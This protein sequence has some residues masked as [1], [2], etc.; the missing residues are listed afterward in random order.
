[1]IYSFLQNGDSA[2]TI[3]F[4]NKISEDVNRRVTT[5]CNTIEAKSINGVIELVPTFASLTVFYDCTIISSKRLK[6]KIKALINDGERS[7][8]TKAI[9]WNIPVC[10]DDEFAPDMENVCNHTS[11]EKEEV[12]RLHTSKPYLIYMLGFLP[13]FAYLGGMDERLFTPRLK[14]PR[15][16]IFEGAIGIGS[17][18]TGI[19]PIASP[20]G[21]Q[22]IGKTPVKVFDKSKEPP[23]L[24]K[25]GDYIKFFSIDKSE[26]FE[27]EKQVASGTYTPTVSEV[28]L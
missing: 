3:Q 15:L 28:E 12:I 27:I 21:W 25:A 11:L 14:T 20:G 8:K 23:I 10:Y 9:V 5:L 17:E 24:Y 16:E 26:Y 19:Y 6:K 2:V 13:G 22:L 18:Q 7:V 4:E 1:M